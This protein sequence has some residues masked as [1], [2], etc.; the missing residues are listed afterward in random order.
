MKSVRITPASS[1]LF[2]LVMGLG[3]Q[4]GC[5][6]NTPSGTNPP[7]EDGD[8]SGRSG[9][10]GNRG[11]GDEGGAGGGGGDEGG[12]EPVAQDDGSRDW[13]KECPGE[14]SQTPA[15]LFPSPETGE[16]TAFIRVPKG[17][18]KDDLV[19][20]TPFFF[21]T[22]NSS[23]F[24]SVCDAMVQF[25]AAGMVDDQPATEMKAFV[26][27]FLQQNMGYQVQSWE[28]ETVEGRKLTGA[29]EV[30]S[31]AGGEGK[32]WVS[33]ENKYN[34][35]KVFFVVLEAHPNAF[36]AIKPT[37]QAVTDSLIV[38]PPEGT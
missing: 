17:M 30:S 38:V 10:R 5:K 9:R 13:A 37:F 35:G 4:P 24:V 11:S 29:I 22:M 33:F 6:P 23:G 3:L 19:E 27:Q 36:A 28:G 21:Q 34:A 8:G 15:P 12:G 7:G 2:A 31:Q 32:L 18:D 14:V 25:M 1:A 20:Q 16:P 26:D